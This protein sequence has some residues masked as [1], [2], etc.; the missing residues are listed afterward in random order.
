MAVMIG[1]ARH[2]EN[3][4]INGKAGDQA[5]GTEVS[6]Q[7]FYFHKKG[8][9]ALRLKDK[10]LRKK[11]AQAMIDACANNH[12]GYGQ[13]TRY[14]IFNAFKKYGKIKNIK[15]NVNGD[16]SETVRT[17]LAEIGIEVKDFTTWNEVDALLSTRAFEKTFV[18]TDPSQLQTGDVLVTRSKGHTAIVTKGANILSKVIKKN[19]YRLSQRVIKRNDKGESVKWLQ[20]Q[21]NKKNDSNLKIDGVFGGNTEKAV[22]SFQ[23]KKKLTVD[24]IVGENTL[25]KLK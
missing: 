17:C 9:I 4:G 20:W 1:S 21:L 16:C 11:L 13:N 19:P 3:G 2:D 25:K 23:R 22:K 12:I 24:G 8:W 15:E 5:N 14:Q 6:I 7:E 18:V 10:K